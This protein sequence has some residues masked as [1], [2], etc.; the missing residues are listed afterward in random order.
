MLVL[1]GTKGHCAL[2]KRPIENPSLVPS[3]PPH[4]D[5]VWWFDLN[6]ASSANA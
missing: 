4:P 5:N 2:W 3:H 1:G 6:K